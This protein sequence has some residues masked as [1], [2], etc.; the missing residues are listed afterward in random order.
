MTAQTRVAS[1]LETAGD[2][3]MSLRTTMKLCG[4][5]YPRTW[6]A[7]KSLECQEIVFRLPNGRYC[8]RIYK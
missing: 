4:Y 2:H 6:L 3:G 7:L 1:L 8:H 5:S